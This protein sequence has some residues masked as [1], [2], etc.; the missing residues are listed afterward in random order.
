MRDL[1]EIKR[2]V[3]RVDSDGKKRAGECHIYERP[4]Y[5]DVMRIWVDLMRTIRP[6]KWCGEGLG[7]L[8]LT[9]IETLM[10]PQREKV[11]VHEKLRP[12]LTRPKT[13]V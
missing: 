9:T 10:K 5:C 6:L 3:V 1:F 8:T 4:R 7:S 11:D 12:S 13:S 2:I